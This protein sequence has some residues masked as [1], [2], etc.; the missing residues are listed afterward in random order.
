M[1]GPSK[2]ILASREHARNREQH[3]W[4]HELHSNYVSFYAEDGKLATAELDRIEAKGFIESFG[5]WGQVLARWPGAIASKVALLV[6]E[7]DD[8]TMKVRMII[9]LRRSGGNG[10]VNLTERVVLPR[11]SDLTAS[12]VDLMEGE[13]WGPLGPDHGYEV[14]VVDFEDAFHTLA[15]REA[16]RG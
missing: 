4:R 14:A 7:R 16:D 2:A 9:D 5:T 6:K 8:G 10:N 1:A 12:I 3:E 13:S 11:L 15:L